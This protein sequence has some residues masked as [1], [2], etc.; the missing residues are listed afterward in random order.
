MKHT[1]LNA[2][3]MMYA[4][5]SLGFYAEIADYTEKV[6]AFYGGVNGEVKKY[7]SGEHYFQ[8]MKAKE[9][10]PDGEVFK[11]M[12]NHLSCKDIK[13]LGRK[14]KNFDAE[15]WHILSRFH[16]RDALAMKFKDNEELK[17]L[18]LSTGN[19]VL[20]EAAPR[21]TLWGIGYAE[22]NPKAHDPLQWRG[23]NLLGN[24]L[25]YLREEIR[26]EQEG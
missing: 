9:F 22:S 17:E 11:Q 15:K 1:D 2:T 25:M 26:E 14:V 21:D 13:A 18:L 8:I 19:A 3:V 23:K 20:A 6:T 16:M 24:M 4:L 5:Q 7:A 12:G 10:D